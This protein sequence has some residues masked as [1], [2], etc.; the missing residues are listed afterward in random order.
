MP[1]DPQIDVLARLMDVAQLR[2]RVHAA[3]LAHQNT[4]GYR[5]RAVDFDVAFRDS[6]RSGGAEAAL[7]VQPTV[8]EPRTTAVQPDG[9]DVS[10]ERE[11][12]SEKVGELVMRELKRL[13][14]IAYI[15]FAS[16]YRN[17]EDVNEFSEAI[18]EV[19]RP[20]VRRPAKA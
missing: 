19:K 15:R 16:V 8:F 17:F 14:K 1:V 18:R 12:A 20:R 3:N 4:P 7:A 9:N 5:A 11:V 2:A 13:D 6:L 10:S